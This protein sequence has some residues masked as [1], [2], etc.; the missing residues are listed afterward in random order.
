MKWKEL[1]QITIVFKRRKQ[2][3]ES[4]LSKT[5]QQINLTKEKIDTVLNEIETN[6]L[7]KIN[8]VKDFYQKLSQGV[9]VSEALMQ[10]FKNE[11]RKFDSNHQSI[12]KQHDEL[13]N[14]FDELHDRICE[15]TKQLKIINIKLE[16]F[17][18]V[19]KQDMLNNSVGEI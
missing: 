12:L 16:K 7:N 9:I 2:L 17:E 19:G 13:Q 3:A 15:L 6:K 10:T 5:K 11:Q 8:Y 1:Q 18:Y 4:E 14:T